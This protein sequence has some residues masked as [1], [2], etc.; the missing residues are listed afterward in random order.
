MDLG[1]AWYAAFTF[2]LIGALIFAGMMSMAM[3]VNTGAFD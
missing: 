3:Q 1:S 2:W